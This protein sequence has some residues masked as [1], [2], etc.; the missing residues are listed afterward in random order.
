MSATAGTVR[1]VAEV[2]LK[3]NN[4]SKGAKEVE[5][6][7]G[8]ME[9]KVNSAWT[10]MGGNAEN[11]ANKAQQA[12]S[13]TKAAF[14][15][16]QQGANIATPAIKRTTEQINMAK[17][18]ALGAVTSVVAFGASFAGLSASLVNIPKRITDVQKTMLDLSKTTLSLDR[19]ADNLRKQE[20]LYAQAMEDGTKS[21]AELMDMQK[22]LVF[23]RRNMDDIAVDLIIKEEELI[24]KQ[25]EL[26]HSYLL[27]GSA[28]AMTVLSGGSAIVLTLATMAT[29]AGITTGEFVKLRV[30]TIANSRA[31]AFMRP[32]IGRARTELTLL[33]G[34][35]LTSGTA[36][37]AV[38][39]KVSLFNLSLK[40]L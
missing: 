25:D 1:G 4:F 39:G 29:S 12:G 5:S 24:Q 7:I 19:E 37:S 6:S 27:T 10:T 17:L 2:E 38:T 40:T 16:M 26:N 33:R 8:R 34:T 21:T 15:Q 22:Q 35:L 23:V 11:S 28:V 18:T 13:K 14:V 36:F 31:L 9:R 30:A 20:V 32:N 3:S